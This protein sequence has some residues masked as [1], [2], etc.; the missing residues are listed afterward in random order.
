MT[1]PSAHEL[2]TEYFLARATGFPSGP[3]AYRRSYPRPEQFAGPAGVFVMAELGGNDVGCGGIRLLD[4]DST[5][6]ARFEV[7]HLF[8]RPEARGYGLGRALLDELEGLARARGAT[9]LVLDTHSSLTAAQ[10]LYRASGFEH[11][12]AYN[13]NPNATDWFGKALAPAGLSS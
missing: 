5:S 13:D 12:E 9:E 4:A 11:I 8:I 1:E 3:A 2:L 7:K 10:G 6:V